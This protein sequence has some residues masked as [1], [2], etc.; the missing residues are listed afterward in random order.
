M[1]NGASTFNQQLSTFDTSAVTDMSYMFNGASTFNQQLSTS[2]DTSA[3]TDM[4]YMFNGASTFNQQ[5]STSF[6]TSAV[7]DMSYMFNG[8][9]TFNQ[10][11]STFDTSAVTDMSSM[12]NGASVFNNGDTTD[13]RSKSLSFVTTLVTDMSYMFTNAIAFNQ[14]FANDYNTTQ[15]NINMN[16]MFNGASAFNNGG[17]SGDITHPL[18]PLLTTNPTNVTYTDF[19]VSSP[20]TMGNKPGWMFSYYGIS[21]FVYTWASSPIA[22][23]TNVIP[24]FIASGNSSVFAYGYTLQTDTTTTTVT[25]YYKGTTSPPTY[26]DTGLTCS[27]N[28]TVTFI[29]TNCSEFAVSQFNNIILH[30]GGSQ[31][32]GITKPLTFTSGNNLGIPTI[33]VNTSLV[34]CFAD[35]ANFNSL[36]NWNTSA[37]TNMLGM[38]V[39]TTIFN[40]GAANNDYTKP[41]TF[42][43]NNVTNMNSMFNF[44][45]S[46]NQSLNYYDNI[47]NIQYFNISNVANMNGM[48]Y[49]ASAFNNG[50]ASGDI[51]HPLW[52]LQTTKPT[53]LTDYVNFNTGGILTIGNTPGWMFPYYGI[54]TFVY[55]WKTGVTQNFIST[56][57]P[58]RTLYDSSFVFDYGYTQNTTLNVTT[59]NIYYKGKYSLNTDMSNTT[60]HSYYN[61]NTGAGITI[62]TNANSF[63]ARFSNFTIQVF[64]N[65]ILNSKANQFNNIKSSIDLGSNSGI[66]DNIPYILQNTSMYQCF[67]GMGT[68]NSYINYWNVCNVTNLHELLVNAHTFNKN[69]NNWNTSQVTN[70]MDMFTS[71]NEFNN[72]NTGFN[73]NTSQVTNFDAFMA[74][75]KYNSPFGLN[76]VTTN[77]LSMVNMFVSSKLFNQTLNFNTSNV[78]T[79]DRMFN[80]CTAFNNGAG[81]GDYTKPL[82][83]NTDS[84]TDMQQMFI[85]CT[86]FNQTFNYDGINNLY[87]NTNNVKNTVNMFNGA[88]AFNNGGNVIPWTLP[89]VTDVTQMFTGASVFNNGQ[90][91]GDT[92]H[93]LFPTKPSTIT[94]PNPVTISNFCLNSNLAS[95]NKPSWVV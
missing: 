18:W 77:A 48:F 14:T 6:D 73:C 11:L 84:V 32:A 60:N 28:N 38:F 80:G 33:M 65:I 5:L 4:S 90:I 2:F 52:P 69:M 51:T 24:I 13:I 27:K 92:T 63:S 68:F 95:G 82:T 46:F 72:E 87:F 62:G 89:N 7:T 44:A 29:N 9:S 53:S 91:S 16:Y 25:A 31:F 86:Q 56:D 22:I 10:Q 79:M 15:T 19:S 67:A 74:Y 64:G 57:I 45:P 83:F 42:I 94:T 37:V 8:A 20:L 12:F 76:F 40:N 26:T 1:F 43:T 93:E 34:S 50:G 35:C 23:T 75:T 58:I 66:T 81:N 49:Y 47:N 70:M 71:C 55:T 85:S 39:R 59:V 30:P 88:V 3:V 41:L 17:A 54:S 78:K 21:K 61:V 36:V